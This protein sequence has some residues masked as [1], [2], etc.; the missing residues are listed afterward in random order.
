VASKL[1]PLAIEAL[2]GL[3]CKLE[4]ITYK[5]LKV[6]SELAQLGLQ[7]NNDGESSAISSRGATPC[8]AKQGVAALSSLAKKDKVGGDR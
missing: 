6:I 1:R 4:T 2:F 5:G 7:R 3:D 8:I